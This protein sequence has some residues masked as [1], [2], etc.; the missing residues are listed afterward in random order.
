MRQR[1]LVWDHYPPC[2]MFFDLLFEGSTD[3][4]GACKQ[5]PALFAAEVNA[6]HGYMAD[7]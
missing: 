2:P 5:A 1:E 7:R 4:F 6:F 3:D